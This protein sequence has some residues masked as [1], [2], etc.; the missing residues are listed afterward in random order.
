MSCI[1]WNCRGLG[2]PL[3]VQVLVDM[4]HLKRPKLVFLMETF[5]NSSKIEMVRKKTGMHAGFGVD[6]IGHRG[7][8]ALLWEDGVHVDV[9]DSSPNFIDAWVRMEDEKPTWRFTGFYGFPERH[10]RRE[11]WELLRLLSSRSQLPWLVMGDFN[12]ILFASEKKGRV[13]HPPWLLRGFRDAVY[14]SGL[15]N[16][17][18]EGYQFT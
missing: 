15:H 3:A 17:S 6:S 12:D 11:S 2:N 16:V 8:I 4:I 7:G 18:F 10:R 5:C 13:P 9:R 1:S 14:G